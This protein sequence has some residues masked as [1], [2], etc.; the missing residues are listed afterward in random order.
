VNDLDRNNMKYSVI[1]S[2]SQ[3]EFE[4]KVETH[5]KN[6]WQLVGGVS[7]ACPGG[8]VK[9]AQAVTKQK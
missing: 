7:I 8:L 4:Q 2:W 1:T 3:Q 9:F 6:G 5:L